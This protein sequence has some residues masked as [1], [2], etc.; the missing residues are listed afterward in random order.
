MTDILKLFQFIKEKEGYDIPFKQKITNGYPLTKEELNVRGDLDLSNT[1]ITSLPNGLK[2]GGHLNLSYSK[3]ESLPDG[4]EVG[5]FLDLWGCK[6]L[7]SLPDGLKV[8]GSLIL[9]VT[10]IAS[11]PDGLEVGMDLYLENTPIADKY[12]EKEIRELCDIK[13]KIYF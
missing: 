11:L 9:T 7:K 6:R 10:P 3:I 8:G 5:G 2:V 13:G 12:T 1:K 4:L